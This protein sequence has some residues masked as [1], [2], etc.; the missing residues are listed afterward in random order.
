MITGVDAHGQLTTTAA[1]ESN[2]PIEEVDQ[3]RARQLAQRFDF[4]N[5][6]IKIVLF[7]T[8]LIPVTVCQRRQPLR[9]IRLVRDERR[10][11][12]LELLIGQT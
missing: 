1:T 6:A 9:S 10:A 2:V 5:V 8:N 12:L 3:L 4:N 7:G 11:V